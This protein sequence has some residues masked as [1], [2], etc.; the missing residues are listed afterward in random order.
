MIGYPFNWKNPLYNVK[1]FVFLTNE[2]TIL[3]T[4][5][6]QSRR[7]LYYYAIFLAHFCLF[8]PP[9]RLRSDMRKCP[10]SSPEVCWIMIY[11]GD[12]KDDVNCENTNLNED[13]LVAVVITI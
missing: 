9:Q 8:S 12:S 13:M 5:L 11:Q 1:E 3:V 10:T 4:Q 2:M 7:F 6:C